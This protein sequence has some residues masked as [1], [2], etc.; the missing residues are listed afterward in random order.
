MERSSQKW[1]PVGLQLQYVLLA[2]PDWGSVLKLSGEIIV[3]K[4]LCPDNEHRPT[5][6]NYSINELCVKTVIK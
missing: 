5:V 4:S 6:E 3:I 2:Y 1:K